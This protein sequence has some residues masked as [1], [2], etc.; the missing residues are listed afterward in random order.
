MQQYCE[1]KDSGIEW[2]G[3]IPAGWEVRRFRTLFLFSH[4]V[5]I[6]KTDFTEQGILCATYG[7]VHAK[8]NTELN[9]DTQSL[10]YIDIKFTETSKNAKLRKND[11]VFADTSEDIEGSGNFAYLNANMDIMAGYHTI[12]A[13]PQH[14]ESTRFLAY[15]FDSLWFRSQ[16]RSQVYGVKVFSITKSILKNTKVLL[17]PLPEQEAIAAYLDEKTTHI[18]SAIANLQLQAEKLS[19]Y[20]R[21]LIAKTVTRGLNET[22]TYKDSGIE[23]IGKIPAGWEVRRFRTLFLFSH[24]VHITK[25]DFTEQGILCATYGDVHAKGNTELNPDTQSLH[26]IDIKFTETSKNAKLRKNDFVFA[27]TSEDIEGSG[28]FAYLNANMDIMA[29]YHTIIAKPQHNESTRF[30]AYFFDSLWFRSQI[31]SQVYGVKVFSITKSILKNTKVLLPPLPEQESIAAYLDKKIT[32]IDSITA[33]IQRQIEQ[34]KNYR[35][36]IIH[37]AVTGRIKVPENAQ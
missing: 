37:D 16:I 8:G 33:D 7:D 36:I 31:R 13:K 21:Q 4:G 12:I 2:I 20:K 28:N 19:A 29:G 23:W 17:P 15:F 10:H 26:Y 34:L 35:K 9:P 25:T 27:D 18:D 1:Y 14:N 22:V 32:L 6:T 11:F 5:H 3:K 30:L 24:G